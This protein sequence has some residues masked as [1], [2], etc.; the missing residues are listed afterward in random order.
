[1]NSVTDAKLVN[2]ART[3]I[4]YIP[5]T[6]MYLCFYGQELFVFVGDEKIFLDTQSPWLGLKIKPT[7]TDE[8]E[9]SI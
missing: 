4:N 5:L 7:N 2:I 8:Q 9:R 1:M 3:I 6:K